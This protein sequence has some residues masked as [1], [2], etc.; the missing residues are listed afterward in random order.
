MSQGHRKVYNKQETSISRHLLHVW[1]GYTQKEWFEEA[2]TW[3]HINIQA[4]GKHSASGIIGHSMGREWLTTSQQ[5]KWYQG[6]ILS[7]QWWHLSD[8]NREDSEAL[9]EKKGRKHQEDHEEC[10]E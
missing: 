9:L 6:E 1:C 8:K 7:K 3:Q 2:V 10:P 4:N 5:C